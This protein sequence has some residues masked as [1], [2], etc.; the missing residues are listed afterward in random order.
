[1]TH[2]TSDGMIDFLI[3]PTTR[4]QRELRLRVHG[5]VEIAEGVDMIVRGERYRP[6]SLDLCL[7]ESERG[8]RQRKARR[9][10]SRL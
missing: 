1:M 9:E 6:W 10:G 8:I 2:F 4:L 3:N 7:W 5:V